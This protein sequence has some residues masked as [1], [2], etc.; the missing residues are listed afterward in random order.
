[1]VGAVYWITSRGKENTDDAQVEGHV[2]PVA[3]R[4][5]GQV[6][7]VLVQDNQ[8]VKKGDVL[9]ELDA[10]DYAVRVASAK[11][12]L[13]SAQ[14]QLH[15]AQATLDLTHKQLDANLAIA[16]GGV[17]QASAVSGSTQATIDQA[18]ADVSAAQSRL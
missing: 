1:M 7:Q 13:G 9:V 4:V 3:S 17:S 2:S 10:A 12:D 14:A 8:R 18:N 6:K 15:S 5:T 11:A 16:R